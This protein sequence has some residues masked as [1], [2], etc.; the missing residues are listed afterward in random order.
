MTAPKENTGTEIARGLKFLPGG[1]YVL[2]RKLPHLRHV[3]LAAYPAEL[4]P[5]KIRGQSQWKISR[6]TTTAGTPT[7]KTLSSSFS[8]YS[9]L[10]GFFVFI[11]KA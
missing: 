11:G 8:P 2:G 10:L 9:T 6:Q 4:Y 7:S 5:V 1:L 3:N